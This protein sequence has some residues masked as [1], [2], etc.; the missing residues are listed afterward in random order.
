MGLTPKNNIFPTFGL[1][2]ISLVEFRFLYA[3]ISFI[4][5]YFRMVMAEVRVKVYSPVNT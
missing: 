5:G 1:Y 2:P 4:P 3:G